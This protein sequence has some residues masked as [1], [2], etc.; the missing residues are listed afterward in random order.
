MYQL[1]MEGS[2]ICFACQ[3]LLNSHRTEA[4][5]EAHDAKVLDSVRVDSILFCIDASWDGAGAML[6]LACSC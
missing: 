2:R 1:S 6:G 4:Q 5:H 3:Q